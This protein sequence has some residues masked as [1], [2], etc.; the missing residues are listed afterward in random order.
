MT[1]CGIIYFPFLACEDL[2]AKD[3]DL[4]PGLSDDAYVVEY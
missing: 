1:V 2:G 4:L 3:S